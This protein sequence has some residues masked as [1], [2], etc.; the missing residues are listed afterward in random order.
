MTT[1]PWTQQQ[2]EG[3]GPKAPDV[4]KPATKD[5]LPRLRKVDPTPSRRYRQ[6]TGESAGWRH[7]LEE[8]GAKPPHR[9]PITGRPARAER[10][11]S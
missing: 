7:C 5:L 8:L 1:A 10:T 3:G 2:G 6:R 4:P 11:I 9:P